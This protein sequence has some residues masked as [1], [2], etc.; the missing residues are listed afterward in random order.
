MSPQFSAGRL[1][2]P[3]LRAVANAWPLANLVTV[4]PPAKNRSGSRTFCARPPNQGVADTLEEAKDAL[5]DSYRQRAGHM[6]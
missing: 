1:A 4:Q 6:R 5:A 3:A 2:R